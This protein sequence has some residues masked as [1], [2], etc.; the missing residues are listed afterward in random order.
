ML[1]SNMTDNAIREAF[2][3]NPVAAS[4][5]WVKKSRGK[6]K[7]QYVDRELQLKWEGYQAA[8]HPF[9]SLAAPDAV[10][11][12]LELAKECILN[13][14]DTGN[15]DNGVYDPLCIISEGSVNATKYTREVVSEIDKALAS[16]PIVQPV[17]GDYR[18]YPHFLSD[19]E[20]KSLLQKAEYLWQD[21]QDNQLGGFSGINRPFW[22]LSK[23]R[24]VIE[25]YGNRD[26][27][28]TWSHNELAA[29]P[30]HK[31]NGDTK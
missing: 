4:H 21:L 25:E 11:K 31:N 15:F 17:S 3:K 29:H 23:F 16:L 9:T 8:T 27:G 6:N 24:E 19:D 5:V 28:Q 1:E 22:I 26:T 2:E 14:R 12:A 18:P 13:L 7:G 30:Q 20:K 10:V